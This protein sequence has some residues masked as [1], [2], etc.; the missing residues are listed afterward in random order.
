[1]RLFAT[2]VVTGK[3]VVDTA[4]GGFALARPKK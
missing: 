3:E 4:S 2:D 1:V